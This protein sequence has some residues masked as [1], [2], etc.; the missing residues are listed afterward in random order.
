MVPRH[1]RHVGCS[2]PASGVLDEKESLASPQG[3]PVI[4]GL[5]CWSGFAVNESVYCSA[6]NRYGSATLGTPWASS[7]RYHGVQQRQQ[8]CRPARF[9]REA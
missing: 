5:E 6:E 7:N 8:A 1:T 4:G 2:S 9:T 3:F